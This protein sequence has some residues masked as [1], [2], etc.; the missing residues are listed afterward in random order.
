MTKNAEQDYSDY[1]K[2]HVANVEKGYRWFEA[3][4]PQ[5]LNS[6]IKELVEHHDK[7][8]WSYEEFCPYAD[9]FYGDKE[10]AREA[11]EYAWLHHVHN[12]PHHWEYWLLFDPDKYMCKAYRM[13]IRYVI[14]MILDWWSFSWRK[15]KLTE[16]FDWYYGKVD[17]DEFN[18]HP[19]TKKMVEKILCEM[20]EKLI[21]NET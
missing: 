8:K 1:L 17:N 3:N 12:N 7:S 19:D 21:K 11:F 16:I 6:N 2:N 20:E 18:F 10:E 14:E 15:G 5:Y 13:P 4:L 9:Y